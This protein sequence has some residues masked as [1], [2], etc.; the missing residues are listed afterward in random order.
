APG[1]SAKPPAA[2]PDASSPDSEH[3]SDVHIISRAVYR[4]ND[5]GYLDFKRH[6]HIWLLTVPLAAEDPAPPVQLT[7]GDY[8]EGGIRW[9][10]DGARIYF[11]TTRLDEPYYETGTTDIYSVASTGGM[12]EKLVTIPM[13]IGDL[14]LSPDGKRAAFHGAVSQPVRSYSEPDLWV[15]D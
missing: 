12:P 11:L 15:M 9:T 5:E 1:N 4:S 6:E 8:D 10:S 7:R 3:E 14:T 13:D 2:T